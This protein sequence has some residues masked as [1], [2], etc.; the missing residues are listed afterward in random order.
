NL[1]VPSGPTV[2]EGDK[3]ALVG[4]IVGDPR[5][6]DGGES[7]NCRLTGVAPNDFHVPISESPQSDFGD[8]SNY[9]KSGATTAEKEAAKKA[10][11]D[12]EVTGVV[13]EL[14]PQNRPEARKWT[15]QGL[16]Q[17]RDRNARVL[18]VGQL[19]FDDEHVPNPN[20]V[21]CQPRRVSVW[22]LHP[23]TDIRV[24]PSTGSC[25]VANSD[26][27]PGEQ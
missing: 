13:V 23:V 21:C 3:M 14:I 24:C 18:I 4:F 16:K 27:W 12:A 25:S 9:Q 19:M 26:E 10:V 6:N 1:T 17:L 22:E 8:P 20:D 15:R 11:H 5:A 2:S 7:V